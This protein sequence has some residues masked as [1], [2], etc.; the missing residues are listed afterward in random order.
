MVT[1]KISQLWRQIVEELQHFSQAEPFIQ[2]LVAE[3]LQVDTLASAVIAQLAH[4]LACPVFDRGA[5]SRMFTDVLTH[6][7][8][9]P[10]A[11]TADV[12]AVKQND[13]ACDYYATPL[14]FFKG[15]LALQGY[16]F[17]HLLYLRGDRMTALWLQTRIS[18]VFQVDIH[19]A[20]R[21]AQGI[22]IDHATGIVIGE[23]AEVG[24]GVVMMQNVTLGGTGK[25]RGDRHPK[26]GQGVFLGV[27]AKVLGNIHIGE[28]SKVGAGSIVLHSAPAY[29]TL[30]GVPAK[31]VHHRIVLPTPPQTELV[32]CPVF[33]AS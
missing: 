2:P 10:A 33:D 14:L 20:A 5:L 3:L 7:I 6:A 30:V 23:T 25:E 9:Y 11:V 18:E 12:L 28:Y 4:K 24:Q 27:G 1:I 32:S 31:V 15:F 26:I 8:G 16:R 22:V 29:A 21:L 13:P 17:G 19:P